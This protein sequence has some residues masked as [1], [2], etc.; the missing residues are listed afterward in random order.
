MDV[1]VWVVNYSND[2]CNECIYLIHVAYLTDEA[3]FLKYLAQ[4]NNKKYLKTSHL[5]IFEYT[6]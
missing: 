3:H 6:R 1:G 5:L 2:G 4:I